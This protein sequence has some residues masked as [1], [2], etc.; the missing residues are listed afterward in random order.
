MKI[1]AKAQQKEMAE[2]SDSSFKEPY[3]LMSEAKN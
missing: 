2:S 3:T 1:K